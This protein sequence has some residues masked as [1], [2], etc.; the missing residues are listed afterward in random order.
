MIIFE[1][2]LFGFLFGAFLKLLE[3]TKEHKKRLNRIED[4]LHGVIS[5]NE[6]DD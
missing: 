1:S 4:F 5:E 6:V 2:I 3:I